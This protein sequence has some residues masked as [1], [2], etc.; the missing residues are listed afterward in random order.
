[1]RRGDTFMVG[2]IRRIM[3]FVCVF[4]FTGSV[5]I[6]SPP[7]QSPM[8]T[9]NLI[10]DGGFEQEGEGWEACGNVAL[11][12]AQADGAEFVYSGRY[13]VIM[14]VNAD[15]SGCPQLPD[16]TTPK[17]ILSQQVSIPGNAAA[18]TV[19]FWFRAAAGTTVDVFLANSFYQFDP[20]LIGVKLGT[21]P[22]DQPPGWQLYRTVLQGE[23]LERVR[24]QTLRFAIVIQGGTG[25]GPNTVL[26]IDDVQVI[27]ADGRTAASPLP[28]A[29]RGDGS[30]PLAVIR[31]EGQNRWLYRMDTDG[32][33][34]QLIY[35]GLLDNVRYP[36]W[37]PNG[38]RIAVVDNNTWPWP[39]P[40]SDPQNNLSASAITVINA[41]GSSARQVYQTQSRKGSRCPFL[42]GPGDP[43]E[44]PS[45]IL[46]ISSVQW[47]PDNNRIAATQTGFGVFC[48]GSFAQGGTSDILSV[49]PP[50][51]VASPLAQYAARPSVNRNG[52]VL[53]DGFD[54]SSSRSNRADGVWERDPGAQPP[55]ETRLIAHSADRSPAWAPDGRRFAVVRQTTSPSADVS[56][57][58]FAIM[59]YDRQ[60]L[61]NPRMLLFADHGRS[62]SSLSWSPDGAYLVYTLYQSD[63]GGDIWWLDVS[64]GATGPITTDGQALEAAWRPVS[65]SRVFLPLVVR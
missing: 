51:P 61:N 56:E 52:Q 5:V 57:R 1:M 16:L 13:A 38:Q 62:V 22:T 60:I 31:A 4:G 37:S 19:S 47:L 21:F 36:A 48:N 32:T 39:T 55:S 15:G 6:A 53:F 44:T 26:L 43:T 24:G 2:I 33:N 12:D 18:V 29:L 10:Q 63:G 65:V 25:V 64:S 30:R 7:P 58:T 14:G 27:A 8:N 20:N 42:P 34:T 49:P 3:L 23:R 45:L 59:L 50:S 40:D 11:V 9:S 46:R 54:L 28:P 35:R 17:Q 41:D